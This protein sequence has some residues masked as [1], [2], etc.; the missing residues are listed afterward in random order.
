MVSKPVSLFTARPRSVSWAPPGT[1]LS[2]SERGSSGSSLA[3]M[4][5]NST[6]CPSVKATSS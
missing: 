4:E 6:V 1:L 5:V 2:C 3:L